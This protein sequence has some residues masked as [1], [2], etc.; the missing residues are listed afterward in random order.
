MGDKLY[1]MPKGQQSG[2]MMGQKMQVYMIISLIYN[3][4]KGCI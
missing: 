4:V 3:T 2:S 1:I